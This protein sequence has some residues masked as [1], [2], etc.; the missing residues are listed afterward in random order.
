MQ[1]WFVRAGLAVMA[2]GLV[3]VSMVSAAPTPGQGL[4]IS[5]PVIELNANPGQTV[6]AQIR[7]R[8]VAAGELI[9]K[10]KADDFGPGNSE[11]GQPRLLLE[12]EG[13]ARHS[14]KRWV[15]SV[16]DLRLAP[17]E[18][19]T[20]TITIA[21]PA[22]AEPGGH[23]GVIRFT[24]VPPNVEGTGVALSASVGTLVL[25][26]VAG[27]VI[28]KVSVAEFAAAQGGKK[29]GFFEHGPIDLV[30]RLKNEGTVHEK[31]K[32]SIEVTDGFGK[33]MGTI[34]VNDKGGN[35]LPD[36]IRKFEQQLSHKN[37][38]GHYT[39]KLN[40]SYLNG[41]KKLEAKVG[42]WVIPWK[43]ILLV[44]IALI[45]I[46]YLLRLGLRRY[47]EHIIAQARRH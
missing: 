45:V 3:P 41:T 26:R 16:P 14:L 6:T 40:L 7:V 31:V 1:K 35:V 47:N 13:D 28:D 20:A 38:F 9:A 10:G 42:F 22:N 19:K 33:K 21:V 27:N 43:L 24:A 2:L 39:A 46:G 32:G 17:Q 18:L 11:D 5:P 29:G 23:F 8:N 15:R 36:S 12:E 34:A 25:L 44:L 37:L 4:E 30:V